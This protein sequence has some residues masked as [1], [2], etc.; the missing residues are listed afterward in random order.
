MKS[1]MMPFNR[2]ASSMMMSGI[3]LVDDAEWVADLVGDTG[4]HLPHG[5]QPLR[6]AE[7]LLEPQPFLRPLFNDRLPP[8]HDEQQHHEQGPHQD[9]AGDDHQN[10]NPEDG[11][12]VLGQVLDDFDDPQDRIRDPPQGLLPAQGRKGDQLHLLGKAEQDLQESAALDELRGGFSD[13]GLL[14]RRSADRYHPDPCL[15]ETVGYGVVHAVDV[16]VFHLEAVKRAAHHIVHA[17]QLVRVPELNPAEL[18]ADRQDELDEHLVVQVLDQGVGVVLGLFTLHG[19]HPV[20]VQDGEDEGDKEND[21]QS[22][23]GEILDEAERF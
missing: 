4:R 23:E 13:L 16:Q 21:H 7:L 12:V 22:G 2:V 5:R 6:P 19:L 9:R 14:Q 18:H 3:A 15:V 8:L 11:L 20:G 17:L 1:V 10:L